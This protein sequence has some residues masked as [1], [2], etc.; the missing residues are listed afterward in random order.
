LA[1]KRQQAGI[2]FGLSPL[3]KSYGGIVRLFLT[4]QIPGGISFGLMDLAH[5]Q[6]RRGEI[7][8][9]VLFALSG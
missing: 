7:V 3:G 5:G 1:D 6:L 2:L 8:G 4:D 9:F